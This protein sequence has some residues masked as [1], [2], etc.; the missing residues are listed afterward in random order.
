[1]ESTL[2]NI[3]SRAFVY[4]YT[5]VGLADVSTGDLNTD[6]SPDSI[7]PEGKR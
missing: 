2:V 5:I 1:M 6:R 3:R 7:C 4:I